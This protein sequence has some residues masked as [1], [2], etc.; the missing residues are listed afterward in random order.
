MMVWEQVSG[1]K[2]FMPPPGLDCLRLFVISF[3]KLEG[4]Q[5]LPQGEIHEFISITAICRR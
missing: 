2:F 5:T 1:V 3:M 4:T